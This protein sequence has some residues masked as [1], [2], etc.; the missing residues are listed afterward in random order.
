MAVPRLPCSQACSQFSDRWPPNQNG[1]VASASRVLSWDEAM[2]AQTSGA[3]E[4]KAKTA[5]MV[6]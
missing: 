5:R 1:G 3:T 4:P 2:N 6:A